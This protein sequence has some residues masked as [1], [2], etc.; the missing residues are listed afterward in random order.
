MVHGRFSVLYLQQYVDP[1]QHMVLTSWLECRDIMVRP[2]CRIC[3]GS[4]AKDFA[5]L[6]QRPSQCRVTSSC[7]T[8]MGWTAAS[9]RPRMHAHV[10]CARSGG[11]SGQAGPA[12]T[13]AGAASDPPFH[14]ACSSRACSQTGFECSLKSPFACFWCCC[15]CSSYSSSSS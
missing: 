9:N 14:L 1:S 2:T 15:T 8:R 3:S 13:R 12:S 11:S 10:C 6:T 5:A 4:W 7:N